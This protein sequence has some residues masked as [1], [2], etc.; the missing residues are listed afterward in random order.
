MKKKAGNPQSHQEAKIAKK[1]KKA[2]QVKTTQS[3]QVKMRTMPKSQSPTAKTTT[4]ED[5]TTKRKNEPN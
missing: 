1:M 2:V 4:V 5:L 3:P